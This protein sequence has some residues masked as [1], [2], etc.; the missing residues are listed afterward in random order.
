MSTDHAKTPAVTPVPEPRGAT[1]YLTIKG[2]S[3]AIA[4]Y[5]RVFG[6]EL[7]FR[8]DDPSGAV[9]HAEMQ[10]GPA[11]YMLTEER[12]QYGAVGPKTIGGSPV[13]VI[14]Y[15]PDVD[16]A[17]ARALAAGASATMPLE[18]QFWGDRAGGIA[19]PFGH[20]WMVATRIEEPTP[21]QVQQ[22]AKEMFAKG[23]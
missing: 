9:M 21:Q 2:A 16:A 18:N 15:V 7:L 13:T 22:R 3:D 11:R 19:D 4:F 12:P 6:A 10:V 5:Q 17:V 20:Q 8:I 1:P 23:A 14:V